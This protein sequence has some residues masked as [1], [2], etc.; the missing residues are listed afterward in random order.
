MVREAMVEA[1]WKS[2]GQVEDECV[3]CSRRKKKRGK[4]RC[5]ASEGGK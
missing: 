1:R 2:R 5:V 3:R 4:S